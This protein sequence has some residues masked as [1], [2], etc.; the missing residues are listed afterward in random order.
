MVLRAVAVGILLVLCGCVA[1][2]PQLDPSEAMSRVPLPA[3]QIA[4]PDAPPR[5]LGVR[6]SSLVVRPGDIWSGRIVTTSNVASLE[7]RSPS[8]TFNAPRSTFGEF[9]FTIHA[10]VIPPIYLRSYTVAIVAR[11]AAGAQDEEDIAI[12]F[13]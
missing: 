13:K 3:V 7:V 9:A 10:L 4:A 5:I 1:R 2:E 8:F 6:L 12:D 11:N